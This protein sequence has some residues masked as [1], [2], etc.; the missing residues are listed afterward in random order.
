MLHRPTDPPCP[1]PALFNFSAV[2]A[3]HT[4]FAEDAQPPLSI[5]AL[6]AIGDSWDRGDCTWVMLGYNE[7][8]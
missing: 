8:V 5:E 1:L 4:F 3:E 6:L 7:E 2:L